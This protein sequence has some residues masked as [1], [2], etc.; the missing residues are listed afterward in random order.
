MADVKSK[1]QQAAESKRSVVITNY[2][3]DKIELDP[4]TV[5]DF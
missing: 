5:I 1:S 4:S 2:K 3:N